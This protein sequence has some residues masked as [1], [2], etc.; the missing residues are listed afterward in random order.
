MFGYEI[1]ENNKEFC[2]RECICCFCEKFCNKN[3]LFFIFVGIMFCNVN[4]NGK[5]DVFV[6]EFFMRVVDVFFVVGFFIIFVYF[7]VGCIF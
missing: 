3:I 4:G 2:Y 5:W 6:M 1:G 7:V